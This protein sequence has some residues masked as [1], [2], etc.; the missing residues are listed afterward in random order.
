MPLT[1]L[2]LD[3]L[4]KALELARN[5]CLTPKQEEGAPIHPDWMDD[6]EKDTPQYKKQLMDYALY[7]YYVEETNHGKNDGS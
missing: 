2:S 7:Y 5:D 6:L 1:R 4:R 3:P